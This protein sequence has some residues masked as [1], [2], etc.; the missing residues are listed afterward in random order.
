MRFKIGDK[1]R[2][3]KKYVNNGH[4]GIPYKAAILLYKQIQIIEDITIDYVR[5][6]N[7]FYSFDKYHYDEWLE[8]ITI[9]SEFDF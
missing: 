2:L 1:V 7:T 8:H 5:L 6:K 4:T 9:Q 3:K